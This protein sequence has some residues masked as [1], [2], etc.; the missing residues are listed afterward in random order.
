MKSSQNKSHK[1]KFSRRGFIQKTT[2]AFALFLTQPIRTLAQTPPFAF[3]KV[4]GIFGTPRV[5]QA[6]FVAA[7]SSGSNAP[8]H[9][10]QV[11]LATVT[12][13][14]STPPIQVTQAMLSAVAS[15]G[16]NAPIQVTQALLAT[17]AGSGTNAEI[18]TTQAMLVV[19]V[20]T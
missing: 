10:T 7:A 2:A 14:G 11:M 5:T 16:S 13:S 20:A 19:A 6:L 15:S 3:W 18:R 17:V 1:L 12:S 4:N 8:V 9:A